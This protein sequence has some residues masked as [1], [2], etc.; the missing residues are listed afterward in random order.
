MEA[1]GGYDWVPKDKELKRQTHKVCY[2]KD[3]LGSSDAYVDYMFN[4]KS[5]I[6]NWLDISVSLK[7]MYKIQNVEFK[8]QKVSYK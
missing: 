5:L 3:M 8:M 1:I 4:S 6:K 2:G 7:T